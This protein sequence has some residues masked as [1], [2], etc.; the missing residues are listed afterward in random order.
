MGKEF[1]AYLLRCADNS[2]YAGYTTDVKARERAH[3]AGK[4]AKYTRTRRPV[5][6]VYYESFDDKKEA[7]KREAAYKRLTRQEK[8]ALIERENPKAA[9]LLRKSGIIRQNA[10]RGEMRR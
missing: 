7:L 5:Q 4:G 8:I 10:G 3:N 9:M 2:I 1:F 6:L